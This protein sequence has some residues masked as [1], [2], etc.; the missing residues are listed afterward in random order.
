MKQLTEQIA[1]WQ[2]NELIPP[3]GRWFN[4]SPDVLYYLAWYCPGQRA[5][6]DNQ[7]LSLYDRTTAS[8]FTVLR[9]SL[10]RE[11]GD[12]ASADPKWRKILRVH[13]AH[14]LIWFENRPFPL[15]P[16][17]PLPTLLGN[18]KEW[19]LLSPHGRAAAFGWREPASEDK[20]NPFARLEFDSNKAAFGPDA[21]VAPA[22]PPP[23]KPREWWSAYLTA[24]PPR[25]PDA[26][27]AA[28]Q[29]LRF[30]VLTPL[31]RQ[32]NEKKWDVLWDQYKHD[33]QTYAAAACLGSKQ[34]FD[35]RGDSSRPD[36]GR[37][38]FAHALH[39][40]PARRGD[41]SRQARKL[42]DMGPPDAAL[43][44]HPRRPPRS[45]RQV[46]RRPLVSVPRPELHDAGPADARRRAF[47]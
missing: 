47:R 34:R 40:A 27:E 31:W 24:E 11:G 29:W 18:P 9:K 19:P 21:V 6:I 4:T 3:D 14:L 2:K 7:R 1:I 39:P 17:S 35:N 38:S 23:T 20:P 36:A 32:R 5:F 28:L 12:A 16:M 43:P 37:D 15:L 33:L 22:E 45:R 42:F 41:A 8:D 25:P 44:W 30:E 10:A 46:R 13:D 26:D